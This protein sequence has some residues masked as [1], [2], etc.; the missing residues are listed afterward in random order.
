LPNIGSPGMIAQLA[1]AGY[2]GPVSIRINPGFGHG[3]INTCDT[4]G[5][6]S[7]HGVWFEDVLATCRLAKR[8]GMR[9]VTLHAHIG[10]G[11]KFAELHSNLERLAREFAEFLPRLPDVAAVSLGGGIPHNYR[12]REKQIPIAPLC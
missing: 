12:E 5:P 11:P 8:K 1:A 10:S 7:K 2:R 9:V 4:G 3:H 6:S